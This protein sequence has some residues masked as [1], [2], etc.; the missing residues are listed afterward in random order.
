VSF[1]DLAS[2]NGFTVTVALEKFMAAA[3]KFGLVFRSSQSAAAEAEVRV[4]LARLK[5]DNYRFNLG[6]KEETC[7][8]LASFSFS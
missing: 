4:W 6:S 7:K 3:A 1:K 5:D 2:R 8:S